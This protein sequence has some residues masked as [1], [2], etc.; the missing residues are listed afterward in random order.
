MKSPKVLM[1]LLP[2]SAALSAL[3]NPSTGALWAQEAKKTVQ[4]EPSQPQSST[5]SLPGISVNPVSLFFKAIAI[6]VIFG[7][8]LYAFLKAYK[9]LTQGNS[10]GRSSAKINILGSSFIGPKKSLCMVD[11]LDHLLVL[12][13][14]ESQITVLLDIP[15]QNLTESLRNSLHDDKNYSEPNFNRLLKNW[16]KK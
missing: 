13:V 8:F 7:L 3:P 12:G 16:L 1:L 11:V 15:M 6:I 5:P 2:L 14:T 9:H 10:R 4:P